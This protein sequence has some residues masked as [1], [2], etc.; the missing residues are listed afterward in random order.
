M[1]LYLPKYIQIF[2]VQTFVI[3]ASN[4]R[5]FFRSI[6]FGHFNLRFDNPVTLCHMLRQIMPHVHNV[7]SHCSP[8]YSTTL[9]SFLTLFSCNPVV[10]VSAYVCPTY[11]MRVFVNACVYA[12]VHVVCY[13]NRNIACP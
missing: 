4:D 1:Y 6:C 10:F 9:A 7:T 5:L 8:C 11:V 13:N 2:L 3:S 12:W